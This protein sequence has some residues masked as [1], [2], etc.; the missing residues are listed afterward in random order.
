MIW[1]LECKRLPGGLYIGLK[2]G[3][4]KLLF[5]TTPQTGNYLVGFRDSTPNDEERNDK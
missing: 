2:E 3:K 1:D 4:W 5:F